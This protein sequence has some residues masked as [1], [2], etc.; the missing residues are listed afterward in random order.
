M[1]RTFNCGIGMI[2]V[3]AADDAVDVAAS[4]TAHGEA[5][6]RLGMIVAAEGPAHVIGRGELDLA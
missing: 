1:L 6:S 2:V 3:V 4:L 5:V